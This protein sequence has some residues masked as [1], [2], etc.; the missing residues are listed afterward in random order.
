MRTFRD[1]VRHAVLF[2]LIG[3]LLFIPFGALLF[4]LPPG[5]LGVIGVVSATVATLWN[6]LY[7]IG[8]DNAMQRTVGHTNKTLRHRIVHVVLFEIGLLL[9]L[10]PPIAWYLGISLFEAFVMDVAFVV[11]FLFYAFAFNLAYDRIFPVPARP[12]ADAA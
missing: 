9:L 1:R 7:N 6:F 11:F 4:G 5:K 2:E 3:L 12:A 8:F 10:L